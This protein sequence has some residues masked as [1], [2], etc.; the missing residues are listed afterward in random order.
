MKKIVRL[1]EN[2]LERIVRK[3]LEEQTAPPTQNPINVIQEC[4]AKSGVEISKYPSCLKA[5][6]EIMQGKTPTPQS[7]QACS[8]EIMMNM[9]ELG[10]K[11]VALG[12]CVASKLGTSGKNPVMF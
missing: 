10:N 6:T 12:A 3:V 1:T 11:V 2:D 7:A 9:G 4:F 8:M 5:G